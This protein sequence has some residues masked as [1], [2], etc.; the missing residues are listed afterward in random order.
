[1]GLSVHREE[2]GGREEDGEAHEW[3]EGDVGGSG[4]TP[5]RPFRPVEEGRKPMVVHPGAAL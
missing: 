1:M 3:E 2:E 4:G 5:P